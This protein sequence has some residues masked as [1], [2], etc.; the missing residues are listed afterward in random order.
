MFVLCCDVL[1]RPAR[2]ML[3]IRE[4]KKKQEF[5]KSKIQVQ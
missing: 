4:Y 3:F 5:K 2:V 1:F